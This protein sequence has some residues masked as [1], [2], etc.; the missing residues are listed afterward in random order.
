KHKF[1]SDTV[2][3]KSDFVSNVAGI[4]RQRKDPAEISVL[5]AFGQLMKASGNLVWNRALDKERSDS[6]ATSKK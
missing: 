1:F 2:S 6:L 4:V 3:W 5:E